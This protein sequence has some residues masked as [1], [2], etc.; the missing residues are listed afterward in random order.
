[1]GP[2]ADDIFASFELNDENKKKYAKVKEKFDNHFIVIR[3]VIFE[4]AKFN[5]RKQEDGEN[6]E[7]FVISLYTLSEHCG[8][9]DLR[10][11]MIRDRIVDGIKDANLSVKMQLDPDI[12]LKR[13]TDMARQSESVRKQQSLV[14]NEL[15]DS[16]IDAVKTKTRNQRE[17]Q[18]MPRP[19]K[20]FS[21][22]KGAGCR[23]CGHRQNHSKDNCPAKGVKCFKCSNMEHF[24]NCCATNKSVR[25]ATIDE[26]QNEGFLGTIDNKFYKAW[27]KKCCINNKELNFKIDTGADVTVISDNDFKGIK[28]QTLNK[29]GPGN[30]KLNVLGNFQCML[31][32]EDKFS[33]QDIYVV[34]GLTKPLLGRLA[35]QALG[36]ISNVNVS[37]VDA[38]LVTQKTESYYRKRYPKIFKGLEKTNWTYTIALYPD[39][40]PFA[41]SSRAEFHCRLWK[42]LKQS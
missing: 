12:A 1:M 6:V 11:E 3:N 29:S 30:S 7:N 17:R 25:S 40:K 4:R 39:A 36:I 20:P 23:R 24:A 22:R 33:V 2:E 18:S 16:T 34:K 8:Y 21:Q 15:C 42:K 32:S 35:I 37:S 41:L 28:G 27:T 19:K 5:K 13:A 31:E 10:E 38:D 14:R 9:N 26:E